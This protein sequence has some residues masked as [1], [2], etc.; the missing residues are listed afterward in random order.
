M[1]ARPPCTA[2]QE[3]MW[4]VLTIAA[5]VVAAPAMAQAPEAYC[6]PGRDG[7]AV[8]PKTSGEAC[9]SGYS[10][11]DS[12]RCCRASSLDIP[13]AFQKIPDEPCPSE[14]RTSGRACLSPH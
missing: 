11:T 10:S 3:P 5:V 8:I 9:P 13:A 6:R 2:D 4:I 14:N 1:L 7:R 12:A